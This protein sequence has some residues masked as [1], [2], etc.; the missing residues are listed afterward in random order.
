MK[1]GRLPTWRDRLIGS[2][3]RDRFLAWVEEARLEVKEAGFAIARLRYE[4]LVAQQQI[5]ERVRK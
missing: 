4:L 2:P 3:F 5:A 1:S